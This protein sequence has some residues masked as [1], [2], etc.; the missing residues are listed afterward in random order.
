MTTQALKER[1]QTTVANISESTVTER[2]PV[3]SPPTHTQP[4]HTT[5][6][7][8]SNTE[9][10]STNRSA[11]SIDDQ[12]TTGMKDTDDVST[13]KPSLT[14]NEPVVAMNESPMLKEEPTAAV[15]TS[16]VTTNKPVTAVNQSSVQMNEPVVANTQPSV[17]TN[18][19]VP[20]TNRSARVDSSSA[21]N[22]K[23]S[24]T[25]APALPGNT[26]TIEKKATA[27]AQPSPN[28]LAHATTTAPKPAASATQAV[29]NRKV[30]PSSTTTKTSTTVKTNPTKANSTN[31]S[32]AVQ[33][34]SMTQTNPIRQTS[35]TT[36]T[37]MVRPLSPTVPSSPSTQ[38]TPASAKSATPSSTITKSTSSNHMATTSRTTPMSIMTNTTSHK[39]TSKASSPTA[40]NQVQ[41]R[42]TITQPSIMT[43]SA[44]ASGIHT[45]VHASSAAP[46]ATTTWVVEQP[47]SSLPECELGHYL[48]KVPQIRSNETCGETL[49]RFRDQ[50]ELPCVTICNEH[51]E[52]MG[53]IMR[54]QFYRRMASRFATELYYGRSTSR[55]SQNEPLIVDRHDQPADVVDAALAREGEAFYECVLLTDQGKLA[56]AITIRN[57]MELS[58]HLQTGAEQQRVQSLQAS[59][60]YV[61]QIGQ[62]VNTVS[63]AADETSRQ[64]VEIK[65]RTVAGH[66]Q[67]TEANQQF[68]QAQQLVNDQRVQ[69]EQMLEHTVQARKVVDDVAQLAGQSSMLA[70][71]A[72]IEA[73]RAQQAGRGF[74]VVASEMRLLAER[75]TGMSSDI[76]RLLGSL[77][78]MI[79]QSAQSSQTAEQTMDA[80][81]LRI[82]QADQLFGEMASAADHASAQAKHLHG[83]AGEASRLTMLVMD[84]LKQQAQSK[85]MLR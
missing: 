61:E 25:A 21:V 75:I 47:T 49:Q 16:S 36:Q 11:G 84:T 79:G 55:F 10:Q 24:V 72:S 62:A 51:G 69:A 34:R 12:A 13:S 23:Q 31:A 44:S 27:Q 15:K 76:A 54:E 38:N 82:T 2:Q 48:I 60:T 35:S 63:H 78:E 59:Y 20:A 67:L 32:A 9:P 53:L 50:P 8:S 29:S 39:T 28:R 4:S 73:A 81:M 74:A 42:S 6:T 52:P 37:H 77:N 40:T 46:I 56:G 5:T 1:E 30:V 71:N 17:A 65:E 68:R 58:R 41:Q 14:A 18:K 57:L 64:L 85:S 83:T 70:L 19:Q 33:D 45:P 66:H 7:P 22:Q 80:S 43:P 3:A 26:T